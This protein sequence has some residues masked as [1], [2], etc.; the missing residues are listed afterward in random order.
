MPKPSPQTTATKPTMATTGSPADAALDVVAAALTHCLCPL[1]ILAADDAVVL[2]QWLSRRGE[3]RHV[4]VE[5][6][7]HR[8]TKVVVGGRGRGAAPAPKLIYGF[9]R[10]FPCASRAVAH[11]MGTSCL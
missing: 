7:A 6:P 5:E 9:P 8:G 1:L 10:Y 11:H 4:V 2:L 3:V